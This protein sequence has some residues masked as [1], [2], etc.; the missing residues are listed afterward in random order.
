MP[1]GAFEEHACKRFILVASDDGKQVSGYLLFYVSKRNKSARIVHLRV[2]PEFENLGIASALVT[3]LVGVRRDWR[4][5]SL[6]CRRDYEAAQIWPNLGFYAAKE[7]PGRSR[8]QT[9]LVQWILEFPR[10]TLFDRIE[11]RHSI[12]AVL[13]LNVFSHWHKP[14]PSHPDSSGLTARWLQEHVRFF[15]T[16]E[17]YNEINRKV[18]SDFRAERRRQLLYFDRLVAGF[19]DFRE[20]RKI[21]SPLFPNKTTDSR[22]SDWHEVS[23]AAAAGADLFLTTDE[24]IL[25]NRSEIEHLTEVAVRRPGDFLGDLDRYLH[26]AN[27]APWLV[28]GSRELVDRR[29]SN[30]DEVP[31]K[32]LEEVT[33]R[34]RKALKPLVRRF[35]GTPMLSR[36]HIVSDARDRPM[37]VYASELDNTLGQI[38]NLTVKGGKRAIGLAKR[39][40]KS[41]ILE[42][43]EQGARGLIVRAPVDDPL[44]SVACESFGFY[45]FDDGFVKVTPRGVQN[46]AELIQH[47]EELSKALPGAQLDS[48]LAPLRNRLQGLSFADQAMIEHR[49]WPAKLA[50]AAIPGYVISIEPQ[51]AMYLFEDAFGPIL[52]GRDTEL[53]LNTE[54]VYYRSV[55]PGGVIAPGRILW[56]ATVSDRHPGSGTICAC[57]RLLEVQ[58]GRATDIYSRFRALGVYAKPQI[59]QTAQGDWNKPVQAL[60]FDDQETF[61]KPKL[62]KRMVPVLEKHGIHKQ[63]PQS[64]RRI[65][66]FAFLE[67]YELS[68]GRTLDVARF[69][70]TA[71][72]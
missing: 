5:I 64:P 33:G 59:L 71:I 6:R 60:R 42:A 43:A 20:S 13:D 35:L 36:C 55:L 62:W 28:G 67:L 25:N 32:M 49:L 40:L 58:E 38:H 16:P 47:I 17:L 57:S 61:P 45:R 44:L 48:L 29:I 46:C 72:R 3:A 51:Y 34:P 56:Y 21:L 19:E 24:Q 10:E 18:C 26:S 30:E 2:D 53:A 41:R 12:N 7:I 52:F 22:R 23:W 8:D 68:H 50:E 27:Y 4:R 37:A 11:S 9:P 1:D 15:V 14:D 66:A 31:W 63:P 70:P 39:I 69:N 65:P 54:G